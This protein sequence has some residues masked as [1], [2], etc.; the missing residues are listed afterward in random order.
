M[1]ET[2]EVA[3]VVGGL[4]LCRVRRE[5]FGGESGGPEGDFVEVA[6]SGIQAAALL[7]G[8]SLAL[9]CSVAKR[10]KQQLPLGWVLREILMGMGVC[11]HN[12]EMSVGEQWQLELL[13]GGCQTGNRQIVNCWRAWPIN[14]SGCGRDGR[15]GGLCG[16]GTRRGG[17]W[18]R[19]RDR[20]CR[21]GPHSADRSN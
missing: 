7:T 12:K 2:G 10:R 21:Q 3:P 19:R 6:V 20:Q 9:G 18:A 1:P 16:T 5:H 17:R 13:V 4:G 11:G 15:C 14:R 8:L